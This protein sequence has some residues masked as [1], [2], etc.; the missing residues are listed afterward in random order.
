MAGVAYWGHGVQP[1]LA[2]GTL[3]SARLSGGWFV[4]SGERTR[5]RT[6]TDGGKVPFETL[7]LK[8]RYSQNNRTCGFT[9]G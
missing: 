1:E 5:E 3:S 6:T 9:C 7:S 4:V 2:S 8:I